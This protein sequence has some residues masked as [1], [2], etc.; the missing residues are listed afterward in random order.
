ML[1]HVLRQP[2]PNFALGLLKTLSEIIDNEDRQRIPGYAFHG[3]S[4]VCL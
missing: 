1:S 3:Y 2:H 4:M